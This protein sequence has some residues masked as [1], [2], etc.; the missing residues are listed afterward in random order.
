MAGKAGTEG[1]DVTESQ[2]EKIGK[3]HEGPGTPDDDQN[4]G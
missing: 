3:Q 1:L 4:G 2:A